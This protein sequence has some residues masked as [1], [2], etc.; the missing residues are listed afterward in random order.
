[1]ATAV[2]YNLAKESNSEFV[3]IITPFGQEMKHLERLCGTDAHAA[4]VVDKN[5]MR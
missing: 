1:M 5:A 3:S 2:K 4:M